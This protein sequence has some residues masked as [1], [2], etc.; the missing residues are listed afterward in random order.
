M[1]MLLPPF[2]LHEPT[3]VEEA[4]RLKRDLEDS[5]FVAGGSDLLPNYK[6]GLN[7]RKHVISLA[8]VAGLT[9][10][11]P[12]RIGALATLQAL[13]SSAQ[14]QQRLPVLPRTAGQIASP[15][16]RAS[17][18][19][20]GNLML[21]NRCYFFNQGFAWR[22]SKGYCMKADGDVC[23]V[24]PQKEKCY[25]TFSA[26]LP[27][28]LITLG[29]RFK[30]V[31]ASGAREVEAASFYKGDGI[32]RNVRRSDEVLTEVLVPREAAALTAGYLKLRQ[33][34]SWDFPEMG[35]AAAL[36]LD[37]GNLAAGRLVANALE[38]VP[39]VLD[40]LLESAVG[41]PLTDKAIAEVARGVEREVAPVRNTS[42]PPSYRK[43]MAR[44]FTKRLLTELRDGGQRAAGPHDR[45]LMAA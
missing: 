17:A 14:L 18:T 38:T 42:L 23:L 21:E 39:V 45:A 4:V 30:L 26:D 5:D 20:G 27:A 10:V 41:A 29:A 9:A 11:S 16:I 31:S 44:V 15:L 40:R 35:I 22:R 34:G 32:E 2:Q 1:S 19:V 6:W 24:V 25:A 33:R 13:E 37:G 12:E 36:R 8:R 7:A 3:T 43:A 28:P